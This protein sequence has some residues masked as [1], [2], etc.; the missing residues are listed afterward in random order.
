[1]ACE[2]SPAMEEKSVRFPRCEHG[3]EV[4]QLVDPRNGT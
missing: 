4:P 1:M 2:D 3:E